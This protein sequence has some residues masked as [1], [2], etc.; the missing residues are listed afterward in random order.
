MAKTTRIPE[1][2]VGKIYIDGGDRDKVYTIGSDADGALRIGD[3]RSQTVATIDQRTGQ[4]VASSFSG[5]GNALT[6][7]TCLLYTSPSP[8]D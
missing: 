6:G 7:I 1:L 5:D 4:I 3:S 2:V 8:R